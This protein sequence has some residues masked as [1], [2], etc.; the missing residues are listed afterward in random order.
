MYLVISVPRAHILTASVH[1]THSQSDCYYGIG[2]Q[3]GDSIQSQDRGGYSIYLKLTSV[4]QGS[5][6]FIGKPIAYAVFLRPQPQLHRVESSYFPL[7][8]SRSWS[9]VFLDKTRNISA[10]DADTSTAF[11]DNVG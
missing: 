4:P 8:L 11:C 1:L 5:C 3:V 10:S 7:G 6:M 2:G 9:C